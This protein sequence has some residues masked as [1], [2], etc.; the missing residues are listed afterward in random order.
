MADKFMNIS[1]DYAH[2]HSFCSLQLVVETLAT[3][4]NKPTNQNLIKVNKVIRAS[5]KERI[6]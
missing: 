5:N 6:L 4:L 3:Q 1:N 2:N